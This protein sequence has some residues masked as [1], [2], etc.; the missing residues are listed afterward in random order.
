MTP[1]DM[2]RTHAAA[3]TN[4]RPW[5]AAEFAELAQDR[6][7]W[8]AGD[9]TCF[10]VIRSVADEAELLTIATHPDHQ[11]QGLARMLM[12]TWMQRA[13]DAGAQSALLDVAADNAPALRL[14]SQLGFAEN[15]RRKGYYRRAGLP[16]QDAILMARALP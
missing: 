9:A 7:T 13:A 6:F 1:E 5:S 16:P 10:A 11:R 8:F 12:R 14:Y 4:A 2:A 3:F 15:G